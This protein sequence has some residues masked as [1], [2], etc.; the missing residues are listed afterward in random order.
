[1][2]FNNALK[3]LLVVAAVSALV[4][5]TGC[6]PKNPDGRENVS[7][8]ITLNGEPFGAKSGIFAIR[9]DP[10]G[11]DKTAGGHAQVR[12]GAYLLTGQDGVKPG[13]YIVRLTGSATFDRTT[14]DYADAQTTME[15]EYQ[16]TLV[17]PEFNTESD[18]EFEV[19]AGKK[20]VFNYDIQTNFSGE[21]ADG[22]RKKAVVDL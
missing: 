8:K 13:K 19:V 6:K 3:A 12:Q 9:F 1:M 4:V 18:I 15:N 20:N 16:V 10:I 5:T 14:N 7:G 11:E 22:G 21:E 2:K 17:P